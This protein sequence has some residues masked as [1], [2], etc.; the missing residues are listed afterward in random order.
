MTRNKKS[1]ARTPKVRRAALAVPMGSAA[2]RSKHKMARFPGGWNYRGYCVHRKRKGNAGCLWEM[3]D[4]CGEWAWFFRTLAEFRRTC[5]RWERQ[6]AKEAAS[7]NH[8]LGIP[9]KDDKI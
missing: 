2:R 9:V 4:D 8:S 5:D 3:A 6:R 1:S 7:P